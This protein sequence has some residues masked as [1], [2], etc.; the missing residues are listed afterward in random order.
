MPRHVLFSLIFLGVNCAIMLLVLQF[1]KN[2]RKEKRP[3]Y[4]DLLPGLSD[5]IKFEPAEVFEWEYEYIR[6]TASEAMQDRHTMINFYLVFVG[7]VTSAMIAN[8]DKFKDWLG[9][10]TLL[11]SVICIVGWFHFLILTRLREA[12]HE[13]AKAMLS[14]R[15]FCLR[16]AGADPNHLIQAF[17]WRDETLPAPEKAWSVFFYSALLIGFLNSMAFTVGSHL[18]GEELG[19]GSPGAT[20]FLIL[21]GMGFFAFHAWIYRALLKK[22]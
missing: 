10:P 20:T 22:G 18:L 8:L 14:L 4:E 1:V 3:K 9:G 5:S 2:S 16:H 21:E 17:R 15:S 11:T 13:S 12:W 7:V 19:I 6:T